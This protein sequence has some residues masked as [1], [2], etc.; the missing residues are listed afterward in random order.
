MSEPTDGQK[1]VQVLL[2]EKAL[3]DVRWTAADKPAPPLPP[4][5]KQ[6]LETRL[7]PL[8]YDVTIS[9][10][11]TSRGTPVTRIKLSWEDK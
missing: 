4:R 1:Q 3:T 6:A 10:Q 2:M 11:R 9:D 7:H 5:I 8:G